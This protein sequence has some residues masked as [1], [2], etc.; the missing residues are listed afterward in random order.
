MKKL[1]CE[2]C[3]GFDFKKEN[4][5]F[6][7]EHCGCKYS[8]EEA[9]KI[10]IS[11]K[12]EVDESKKLDNLY[13][14]ARRAKDNNNASD[15]E[16]YYSEILLQNPNDWEASFYSVYY[17]AFEAKIAEISNAANSISNCLNSTFSLIKD[18]DK[19]KQLPAYIEITEKVKGISVM[20]SSAVANTPISTRD[21]EYH[22]QSIVALCLTLAEGIYNSFADITTSIEIYEWILQNKSLWFNYPIPKGNKDK[23]LIHDKI[24]K[25]QDDRSRKENERQVEKQLEHLQ[26]SEDTANKIKRLEK[27]RNELSLSRDKLKTKVPGTIW[28]YVCLSVVALIFATKDFMEYA[29]FPES[30]TSSTMM[31]Y[32][33]VGSIV[34]LFGLYKAFSI[35]SDVKRDKK[36]YQKQSERMN[37]LYREI[38][39]LKEGNK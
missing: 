30:S 28:I 5:Y 12:V 35:L 11:G 15:G 1:Q 20:L 37:T 29:R 4:D 25:L 33:I 34:F 10:I 17:K 31:A 39:E 16:K 27:Q 18:I 23:A 19:E 21:K 9:Q 6:V 2:L 36:E 8:K 13:Q 26:V 3:G 7:C 14:L 24:E 32:G 22:M 38:N